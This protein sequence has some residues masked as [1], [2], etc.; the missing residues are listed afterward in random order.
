M[1]YYGSFLCFGQMPFK[2]SLLRDNLTS[3]QIPPTKGK[4]NCPLV[5]TNPVCLAD[6]VCVGMVC[7]LQT[8]MRKKIPKSSSICQISESSRDVKCNLINIV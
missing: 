5:L 7:F 2:L 1:K 8:E 4:F 6:F 3:T